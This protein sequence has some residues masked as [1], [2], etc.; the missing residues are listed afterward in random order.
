LSLAKDGVTGL[1]IASG[2]VAG[3]LVLVGP[4]TL[5][6]QQPPS[7][8]PTPDGP[9]AVRRVIDNQK[10]DEHALDLYERLEKVEMRKNAGDPKPSSVRVF[11]VVPTGTGT[12]RIPLGEDGKPANLAAY[13]TELEKLAGSLNWVQQEG[14]QQREAYEKA[15]KKRQQRESL[16][17]ATA[18]AFLYTYVGTENRGEETL[19]KYR[20]EPNPHFHPINRT[21]TVFTKVRGYVWINERAHEL[22]KVEG[23][24]TED[25]SLGVFL[26][27]VY[28]GSH[29]MQ[30][31]YEVQPGLWAPTFSEYDFDGRKFFSSFAIHERTF[32]WN[33]KR[34]GPPKEA[35]NAIRSELDN[36]TVNHADP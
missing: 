25:I 10:K 5:R 27:K 14:S 33:Y 18:T 35:L 9:E 31:R 19:A 24:V 17:D 23:D 3:V 15:A 12:G 36:P 16:I 21:Q 4:G 8:S 11:R 6:A 32:Y 22:A 13:H 30:E 34:I 29:F 2:V 1:K 20:I 26:A 7:L 28:K